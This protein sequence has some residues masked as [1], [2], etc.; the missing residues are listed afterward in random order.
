[1]KKLFLD[2]EFTGLHKNT[3]LISLSLVTEDGNFFYA[4]FTDYNVMQV[5]GWIKDN[6]IKN[7]IF[8]HRPDNTASSAST[9][10]GTDYN[11]KGN[12]E[13]VLKQLLQW[14]G[15]LSKNS[16]EKFEVWADVPHYDWVLFCD[17]F[18]GAMNLPQ[19]IFYICFDLATKFK[20]LPGGDPDC[21]RLDFLKSVLGHSTVMETITAP[22]NA[23]N[24]AIVTKTI[25]EILEQ[26]YRDKLAYEQTTAYDNGFAAGQESH[27]HS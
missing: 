25:W 13:F 12:T 24:D 16:Q 8:Q 22:H 17:I 19:C 5:D 26:K 6:V 14:L 27:K 23:L 11:V 4:E 21:N 3:T 20:E 10:T 15:E 1:M 2:T 18:G 9:P 7:L